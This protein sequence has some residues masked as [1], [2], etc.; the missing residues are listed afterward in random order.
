MW[1]SDR[2]GNPVPAKAHSVRVTKKVRKLYKI[3]LDNDFVIEATDNHP[4]RVI[5]GEFI[6]ADELLVGTSLMP[7]YYKI[8]KDGFYPNYEQLKI[9]KK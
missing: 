9:G 3:T 5:N 8:E 6:R 7:L 2:N 4:F 1:A